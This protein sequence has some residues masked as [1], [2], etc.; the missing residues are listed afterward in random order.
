MSDTN[1]FDIGHVE[2]TP[3]SKHMKTQY[4]AY[5]KD[6]ILDR[7]IPNIYDGLKPVQRRIIYA[8]DGMHMSSKGGYKKSAR[9]VGEVLGKYHAHGD[10]SVY[11]AMVTMAQPFT[12]R[13]RLVDGKGNWGS[14]D[15]DPP[16]AMRYTEAKMTSISELML[17]DIDKNTTDFVPNYDETLQEP[18]VL[19]TLFPNLLANGTSGIAVGLACS[20]APH[21]VKDIYKAVD[22]MIE[23]EIEDRELSEDKVISIIKAPDFPTG[24][25]IING[26]ELADAYKKGQGRV[27]IRGK[28]VVEESKKDCK[29]IITELPYK[30][31]KKDIIKQIYELIPTKNLTDIK[32]IRDE[33][34]MS[35]I[36]I[37][38]DCKKNANVEFI[39]N[40]LFKYTNLQ[41]SFSLNH[42]ALE[43]DKPKTNI[44]LYYLLTTFIQHSISVIS[45]RSKYNKAKLEDRLQIVNAIY[46]ALKSKDTVMDLIKKS[47]TYD[48]S[49]ATLKSHFNFNDKQAKAVADLKLYKFN[50]SSFDAYTDEIKNLQTGVAFLTKVLTN[51]KEML[52][53]VREE[54]QG[55][56][57][58]FSKEKRLTEITIE[59]ANASVDQR[60]F[61]KEEDIVVTL[62]HNGMIKAVLSKDYSA[63]NRGGKGVNITTKED[64]FI[65]G[66]YQLNTHD[67][68]IFATNQGRFILLPAYKLPITNK[69]ALG[70]YINNFITLEENESIVE[71]LTY[72][73]DDDTSILF[74]TKNGKAKTVHVSNLPVRARA[75]KAITLEDDD[76]LVTCSITN[77]YQYVLILTKNGMMTRTPVDKISNMGRSGKGSRGISLSAGDYVISA[78]LANNSDQLLLVSD[79][80]YGKLSKVDEFRICNRGA[81]GVICYKGNKKTGNVVGSYLVGKENSYLIAITKNGKLIKVDAQHIPSKGRSAKGVKIINLEDNDC[82]STVCIS[83]EGESDTN[84]ETSNLD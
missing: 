39:V 35:G 71:V 59:S 34:D 19:P 36:R 82:I 1:K 74:V 70:K 50:T 65:K 7:A 3:F 81:K 26:H 27:I 80:G 75:Y 32:D 43:G 84:E 29:I 62:T 54:L 8:M 45:R 68:L 64:D 55:I 56:A 60:A 69:G 2:I 72:K 21:N 42:V 46:Q 10:G 63:Q 67:D 38:I 79:L 57:S 18:T 23:A 33:S 11:G 12:T 16:A 17:T 25:V 78:V 51:K 6:V 37:V 9:T 24:G 76:Q 31:I 61:I 22:K 13:Y 44:S 41:A 73:E 83:N 40:N 5:A 30:Q 4:M 53:Y 47:K 20:F 58:K 77:S 66:V 52:Q 48:D 28:Y 14:I 49:I 15:D